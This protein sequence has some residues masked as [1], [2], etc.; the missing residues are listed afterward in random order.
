MGST[1]EWL[2]PD[3]LEVIF[4]NLELKDLVACSGVNRAW[5]EAANS[6]K[7]WRKFVTKSD[8]SWLPTNMNCEL[9]SSSSSTPTDSNTSLNQSPSP[10]L[11][12]SNPYK[13]II[14]QRNQLKYNWSH[15]CITEFN[16]V[17]TRYGLKPV[18]REIGPNVE[19]TSSA[20]QD[21][22]YYPVLG[23]LE[24]GEVVL[25]LFS[26]KSEVKLVCTLAVDFALDS[27]S[28][29]CVMRDFIVWLLE[30]GK[31]Q[32]IALSTCDKCS[33]KDCKVQT[34]TPSLIINNTEDQYFLTMDTNYIVA[35]TC[36]SLYVWNK[37]SLQLTLSR[38]PPMLG[39]EDGGFLG[40]YDANPIFLD[41]GY[42]ILCYSDH[43]EH[44]I[45]IEEYNLKTNNK[46]S[47]KLTIEGVVEM[48]HCS[49][50][51]IVMITTVEEEGEEEEFHK[52]FIQMRRKNDLNQL[53]YS[54]YCGDNR[55]MYKY[56][57]VGNS[58][59]F[60]NLET[61]DYEEIDISTGFR[62]SMRQVGTN[63]ELLGN[64][65]DNLALISLDE[66]EYTEVWDWKKNRRCVKLHSLRLG[67]CTFINA[68]T[69]KWVMIQTC[70]SDSEAYFTVYRCK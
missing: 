64:L 1:A 62:S 65:F 51:F 29:V 59:L 47:T 26:F 18:D 39:I 43:L 28:I 25:K 8:L 61:G 50:D 52:I 22:I 19:Y 24:N 56:V 21:C 3:L 23:E 35:S 42:L 54:Y 41:D 33:F 60:Y 66:N 4:S 16:L 55:C 53:I 13:Q 14:Q 27:V 49:G 70:Y 12:A 5:N 20:P 44:T 36:E 34:L 67:D 68:I 38:I 7:L 63:C 48:V 11:P 30:D 6:V 40:S 45:L 15:G 2:F 10:T 58:F 32:Y 69:A 31:V 37:K 57:F 46:L 9:H 17:P